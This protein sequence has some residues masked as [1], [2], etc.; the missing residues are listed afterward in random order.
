MIHSGIINFGKI[1]FSYLVSRILKRSF[2]AGWPLAVSIEP[3]NR[4]NLRCP[5][6]PS[7]NDTLKRNRGFMDRAMFNSVIDQLSPQLLYLTLYFEGEPFL[8]P[9]FFDFVNYAASKGIFVATSTNGHFLDRASAEK[10][11]RSGLHKLIISLDGYDQASYEK[12]RIG[13]DFGK[14]IDGLK[15]LAEARQ[16][17]NSKRPEIEL[18]CLLFSANENRKS[19]IRRLGKE[20]GADRVV[21]KTA[22]FYDYEKGNPMMPLKKVHTRYS[23]DRNGN[24]RLKAHQ[25]NSCFRMW[26]SCVITWDGLV[27]P[28]CFDKDGDHVFG[29]LKIEKFRDIWRSPKSENFRNIILKRRKSVDICLNCSQTF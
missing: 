18:Q 15:N 24:L 8:H 9:D 23:R 12:Y 25:P 28:C 3:T 26:S 10:T 27:V 1:S 21:F 2:H 29:D 5:E 20:S 13:G 14:V 22:Q 16:R 6:C 11:V 4:C 19:E 7:G 17:L